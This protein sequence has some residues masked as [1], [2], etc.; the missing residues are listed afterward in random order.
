MH[1]FPPSLTKRML[2]SSDSN[3]L[4]EIRNNE[5][6]R[7]FFV[8]PNPVSSVEHQHWFESLSSDEISQF[9]IFELERVRVGYLRV[10]V[11]DEDASEVSIGIDPSFQGMGIASR[12]FA[13][14]RFFEMDS[15][16]EKF[17]TTVHKDNL[18]SLKLFSRYGFINPREHSVMKDF[19]VLEKVSD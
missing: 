2:Q 3:W 10:R 18:K 8:N 13:Q 17:V 4:F 12:I 11:S 14:T 5:N 6:F 9:W 16:T 7:R 15:K 1:Q 19:L